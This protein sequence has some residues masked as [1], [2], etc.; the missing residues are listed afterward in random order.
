MMKTRLDLP[1]ED[2]T[3]SRQPTKR[4]RLPLLRCVYKASL[5]KEPTPAS[6]AELLLEDDVKW[7]WK[8]EH[9][10]QGPHG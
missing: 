6:I 5:D 1:D 7:A 9:A 4:V 10:P 2:E 8:A 3:P